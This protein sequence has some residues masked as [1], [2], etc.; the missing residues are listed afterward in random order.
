MQLE[1]MEDARI[2]ALGYDEESWTC[3]VR[4]PPTRTA[5]AGPMYA[6]ASVPPEMFDDLR[7][8][9][10]PD[11][12]LDRHMARNPD[13]PYTRVNEDGTP[14]TAPV[15]AG[16]A[17][18]RSAEETL[19]TAQQI[20]RDA[21]AL[22]ITSP[23]HYQAAG[24]KLVRLAGERRRRI[25]FFR[26]MK[27]AAFAAHRA[28]CARES[29]AL[30]PLRRAEGVLSSVLVD[31]R[32]REKEARREE[33]ARWNALSEAQL[34]TPGLPGAGEWA[35][36][37]M[38]ASAAVTLP[39]AASLQAPSGEEQVEAASVSGAPSSA[40]PGATP[41]V[42]RDVPAVSG[43]SFAKEWDFE[44]LD[45]AEVPLSHDFYS[46]DP[47]KLRAYVRRLRE[48]ASVPGVRVY[49]KERSRARAA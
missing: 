39:G 49:P 29:E 38:E 10:S 40:F 31:Y 8:S 12:F 20:A 11:G 35:P 34:L 4:F 7:A 19:A 6:Y 16:A 23:K 47:K 30:A 15:P 18:F 24:E 46:L 32:Q 2:R 22:A 9:L 48:H 25:E 37:A 33:Q 28:V 26:P 45:P 44:V 41:V 21:E 27:E 5:P 17:E 14:A 13:H 1:P 42:A 3:Y 43:L 36:P